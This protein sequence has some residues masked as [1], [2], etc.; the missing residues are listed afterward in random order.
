MKK[1]YLV[2]VIFL[3]SILFIPMP[4]AASSDSSAF[5]LC[6]KTDSYTGEPIH[7]DSPQYDNL[8]YN[9][10]FVDLGQTIVRTAFII[11]AIIGISGGIYASIRNAMFTPQDDDDPAKYVRMRIKLITA[12]L[13]IP[14]GLMVIGFVI[15]RIT[16]YEVTCLLPNIL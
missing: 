12:G 6:E 7:P 13:G 15:E 4:T 14:I 11:L 3:I 9:H 1:I 8:P 5:F 2:F 10:N 16:T